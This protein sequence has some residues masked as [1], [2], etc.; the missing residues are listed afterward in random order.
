MVGPACSFISLSFAAICS[1]SQAL[2]TSLLF[3][4]GKLL[5]MTLQA[6]AE[7]EDSLNNI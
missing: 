3:P 6:M 5:S 7:C 2:V 4:S 1:D